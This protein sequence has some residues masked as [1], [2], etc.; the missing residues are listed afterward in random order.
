MKTDGEAASGI[1]GKG[2][3]GKSSVVKGGSGKVLIGGVKDN[4]ETAKSIGT[5]RYSLTNKSLST[6]RKM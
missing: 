4:N 2:G 5:K 1:L 3:G 6:G